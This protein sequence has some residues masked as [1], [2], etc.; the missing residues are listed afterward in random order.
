LAAAGI[1]GIYTSD[2]DGEFYAIELKEFRQLARAFGQAVE[3]L[4]IDAAMG[5]TWSHTQGVI[6]RIKAAC[7]GGIPNVHVAFPI[8]M[9]LADSDVDRFW[10]DL[11]DASPEAKWVHYAHPRCGPEMTGADYRRLSTR[12]PEQFIG[13]K[14]SCQSVLRLTDI[15][16][17]SPEL[18]H[19]VTDPIMAVGMMIGAKGCY[20]YWFNTL[21]GWHRR[22]MDACLADDW[23]TAAACHRKLLGWELMHSRPLHEAG[24]R[25]GVIGK[26][27]AILTGFLEETGRTRPPYY[28]VSSEMQREYKVA[29]EAYWSNEIA[30]E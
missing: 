18:A 25:H 22:Y 4:D 14:L 10:D 11:A 30:A 21:P 5:V 16:V 17:G 12:H 9:P 26:A 2:S 8:F 15:L 6:D 3:R 28:P 13:T 20:S 19:F 7:D 27:R 24:H 23:V 29:F 1:D